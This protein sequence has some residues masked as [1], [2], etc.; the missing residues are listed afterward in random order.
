MLKSCLNASK[1]I[2]KTILTT[3][4]NW[5]SSFGTCAEIDCNKK[6]S[7]CWVMVTKHVVIDVLYVVKVV[8]KI[9]SKLIQKFSIFLD[10][11]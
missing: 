11:C 4:C 1:N 6:T 9:C 10:S 3:K 5:Q 7:L 8:S 2:Q